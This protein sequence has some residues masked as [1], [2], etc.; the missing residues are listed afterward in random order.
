MMT[1]FNPPYGVDSASFE[2]GAEWKFG[3]ESVSFCL[4]ISLN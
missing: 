1:I 2:R 4:Y 3:I